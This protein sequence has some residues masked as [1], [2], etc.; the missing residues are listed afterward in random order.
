ME[1]L[2]FCWETGNDN[3][4]TVKIF[5]GEQVTGTMEPFQFFTG[6]GNENNVTVTIFIW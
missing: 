4:V 3:D 6:V 2:Q 1:P 5:L